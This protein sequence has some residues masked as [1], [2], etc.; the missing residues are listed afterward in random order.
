MFRAFFEKK[1]V[2]KFGYLAR[3]LDISLRN[4]Y[5]NKVTFKRRGRCAIKIAFDTLAGN[6][7]L[8]ER[9][10][11]DILA[12]RLSHAYIIEG[13][14]GSGKHTLALQIAAAL[15]C[16]KKAN[17]A[18]P[19]PCRTCPSCRK[20]LSGNCPDVIFISRG[21]KATLGVEAIRNLKQDVY[22]APNDTEVKLYIIE[23]AHLMTVQAQNALLLTLEEPPPYVLFLLLCESTAPLLET[24][25]SR[26]PTLRTEPL[27]HTSV[28]T[29][30]LST[31]PEAEALAR[32]ETNELDELIAAANGSIGV[33]KELLD[34]KR[35]RPILARR[36]TA[37]R[38]VGLCAQ[39][40]KCAE[41]QR[42][43]ASLP[44]KR[45]ELGEVLAAVLL[46]LRDL[47]LC[48]QT[49]HAPLCFFSDREEACTLAYS[50]TT[51]HLMNLCESVT[52]A[53]DSLRRNANVRLNLTTLAI[54]CGL[55]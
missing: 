41:A 49:E 42:F 53:A 40:R 14:R 16:E 47:L 38:F 34:P 19:L 24:V 10:G 52:E 23:D 55:L 29:N 31:C 17:T 13:A 15:A 5:N 7:A 50:F 39:T 51:P 43:L 12:R 28:R 26:A 54:R 36:E 21:D 27:D 1:S 35:R 45:D 11:E 20:I 30:L 44:Q 46:C 2:K 25:K 22:I 48:K 32:T 8:R 18:L 37:R 4:C 6:Q 33:A 3:C 9:L